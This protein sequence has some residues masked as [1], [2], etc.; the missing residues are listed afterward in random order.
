[1]NYYNFLNLG[2]VAFSSTQMVMLNY[3]E[4]FFV[5]NSVL[6]FL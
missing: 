1:M 6:H 2:E 4:N 5:D 3:L